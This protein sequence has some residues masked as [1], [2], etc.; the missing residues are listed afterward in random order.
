MAEAGHGGAAGGVDVVVAIRIAD[1]NSS[2]A[3]CD[4][5]V[6]ADLAMKDVRHDRPELFPRG[7]T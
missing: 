4:R 2:P 7:R 5:V 1:E 6:V 3:R